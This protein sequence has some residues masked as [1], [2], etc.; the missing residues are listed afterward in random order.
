MRKICVLILA[1]FLFA[2]ARRA[3][4]DAA[5]IH[6]DKLPRQTAVRAALDDARQLEPYCRR[7]SSDGQYPV[8]KDQVA[9][10]L[11]KDLGFLVPALKN[12][13]RNE[14]LALL[15][16]LVAHYAYN[17]DVPD[18]HETAMWALGEA[19]KLAPADIRAAWF[20]AALKCQT[21]ESTEGADAFLAIERG[22]KW[23]QL[24][25][26]FW[27]D[28]VDCATGTN[29]P[30]H[31]LRAMGYLKQL[32]AQEAAQE[33]PMALIALKRIVPFDPARTYETKE[34]WKSDDKDDPALT[35][36]SCGVR[37]R[38]RGFWTINQLALQK[39]TCVALFQTGAYQGTTQQLRPG[40]LLL[41]KQPE[42]GQSLEDF[43]RKFMPPG[44]TQTFVPSR[45][46]AD[47]CFG[48][49][50]VQEGM[51]GKDGDGHGRII[52]FERDQPAFPGLIFESPAVIPKTDKNDSLHDYR[53][54]ALQGRIPG[55]L[56]Y[57]VL[58]DAAASIEQPA[59]ADYDYFLGNLV[60]E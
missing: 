6:A 30:E 50:G 14:E 8:T 4:A 15:T 60:V 25:A 47:R 44:P 42:P 53:P 20:Q 33:Q 17:L 35:S 40:I 12:H 9:A 41:V 10:R 2:S 23:N 48:L 52:V 46:P 1:L 34:V 54:E 21:L 26:A 27:M 38:L 45:C 19:E 51:Y 49:A 39:S 32:N 36:T 59:L 37:L 5:A 11:T 3:R 24:P 28:Y 29:M 16:G 58:L 56:Y 55:H 18:T 57:L 22:H 13:P 31:A 7:W 43:A